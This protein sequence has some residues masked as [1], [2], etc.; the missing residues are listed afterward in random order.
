[1]KIVENAGNSVGLETMMDAGEVKIVYTLEEANYLF[2][3]GWKLIHV[4]VLHQL[5]LGLP[6][7]KEDS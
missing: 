2:S 7:T 6:R 1:M 5:V 4:S 3:V